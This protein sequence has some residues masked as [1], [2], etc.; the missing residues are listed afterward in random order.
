MCSVTANHRWLKVWRTID[1]EGDA[2]KTAL[3]LEVLVRGVFERQRFLDLH[4]IV[5]GK[6]VC[7][8]HSH[9]KKGVGVA[10]TPRPN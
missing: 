10:L 6:G 3:E 7:P 4:F 2:P 5:F 9:I 1:G 8:T